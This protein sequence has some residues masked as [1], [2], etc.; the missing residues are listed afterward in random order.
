MGWAN[1]YPTGQ[2]WHHTNSTGHFLTQCKR[3]HRLHLWCIPGVA[4]RETDPIY[5][6]I[7]WH[8]DV[9]HDTMG[10]DQQYPQGSF[11]SNLVSPTNRWQEKGERGRWTCINQR[12]GVGFVWILIWE[13][14][15]LSIKK[16][17]VIQSGKFE[18]QWRVYKIRVMVIVCVGWWCYG[19]IKI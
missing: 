16:M 2:S 11:T 12:Q 4:E 6:N 14:E 9:L 15:K 10:C 17:C 1:T 18:H 7:K 19:Y 8:S 3:K 5:K 13:K